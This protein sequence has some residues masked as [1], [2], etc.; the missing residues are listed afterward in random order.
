MS[1][2]VIRLKEIIDEIKKD[3]GLLIEKREKI[4]YINNK[5]KELS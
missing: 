5:E 1:K 3:K 4:V 2:R